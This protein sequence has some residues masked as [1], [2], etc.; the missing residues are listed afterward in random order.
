VTGRLG[1]TLRGGPVHGFGRAS[2]G[3]GGDARG[4]LP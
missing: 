4:A 1:D 2:E 3:S